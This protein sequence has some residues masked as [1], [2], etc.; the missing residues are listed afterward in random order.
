MGGGSLA[1]P[2]PETLVV[3][4]LPGFAAGEAG[5]VLDAARTAGVVAGD[6][7]F[8]VFVASEDGAPVSSSGGIRWSVQGPMAEAPGG[9]PLW[10]CAGWPPPDGAE[11]RACPLRDVVAAGRHACVIAAGESVFRL[12][13]SGVL[14]GRRACVHWALRERF[15][16]AFPRVSTVTTAFTADGRFL[17]CGGATAVLDLFIHMF[18]VRHGAELGGR[19]AERLLMERV[20]GADDRQRIPLLGRLGPVPPRL[21]RAVQLMESHVEEPLTTDMLAERVGLSRRQLERLFRA[22]VQRVPSQYYLELRLNRAR[23]RLR[24]TGESIIQIGLSCG[25]SSGPHFSSAYRSHFGK[26][27]R[28]ERRLAAMRAPGS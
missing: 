15:E 28:D 18:A 10:V 25:F 11:A 5:L 26:T 17:T 27:P 3:L 2:A 14:E 12:A 21:V 16:A 20:R 6:V 9:G 13:A 22:H 24:E 1:G 7:S 19:L 23:E 4:L 8:N